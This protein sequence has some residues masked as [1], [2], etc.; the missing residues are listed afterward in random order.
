MYCIFG[1]TMYKKNRRCISKV[2]QVANG[3]ALVKELNIVDGNLESSVCII[4][5]KDIED[6]ICLA[7]VDG[8]ELKCLLSP[9]FERQS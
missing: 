5:T 3:N 4:G 2:S 6:H 9:G 8:I 1:I 7:D